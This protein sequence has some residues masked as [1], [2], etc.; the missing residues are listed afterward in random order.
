M[1]LKLHV[2]RVVLNHKCLP[3]YSLN[4][5]YYGKSVVSAFHV[6]FVFLNIRR[7]HFTEGLK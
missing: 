5:F 1:I 2:G 3:Y 6:I 7:V 4:S